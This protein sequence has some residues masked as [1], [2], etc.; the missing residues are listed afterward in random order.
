[1]EQE[2][3]YWIELGHCPEL[4]EAEWRSL[5]A[6]ALP[7]ATLSREGDG[8]SVNGVAFDAL[9]ALW[10]RVG[11]SIR[12]AERLPGEHEP[13]AVA[14]IIAED[15]VMRQEGTVRPVFGLGVTS[16]R[17]PGSLAELASA[18]K[19]ELREAGSGCR[20]LL[21]DHGSARLPSA[22][23][24]ETR[25][26]SRGGEYLLDAPQGPTA[27]YRTCLLQ[28]Y[29]GFAERDFG[30][31]E[32]DMRRGML[33]PKLA[34]V[35]L[36]LA[37]AGGERAVV[38]PF[39]GVGGL[40][41][42][43]LAHGWRAEGSDTD[44]DAVTDCRSNLRWLEER[45]PKAVGR[46][47][48]KQR[49]ACELSHYAKPLTLSAVATEPY[50]G[51]PLSRRFPPGRAKEEV[52]TLRP[53]YAA[54]LGQARIALA[55]GR[56]LVFTAPVWQTREGPIELNLSREVFLAGFHAA[57]F[58]PRPLLY[59]RPDQKVARRIYCLVA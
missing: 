12:I 33:P 10:P 1:M 24:G 37:D 39:C 5:A 16:G 47:G 30:R 19:A 31:P 59:S 28:D 32:R 34:L 2:H 44:E 41:V 46:W 13:E 7:G 20:F 23:V 26:P 3:G 18:V 51:P 50:L 36:N 54:F 22:T 8:L 6:V 38:D 27:I 53:L 17:A 52:E 4:S 21:P 55:P 42:E 48:V 9:E 11:G 43:A 57:P 14:G 15:L 35:M 49:D 25:M 40:L 45:Y 56:R 29:R 58:M